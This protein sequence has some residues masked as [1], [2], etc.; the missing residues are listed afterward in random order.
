MATSYVI[1]PIHLPDQTMIM[2]NRPA[3]IEKNAALFSKDAAPPVK[4]ETV[5][6]ALDTTELPAEA[7]AA[8]VAADLVVEAAIA[9][10]VAVA[11][12]VADPE[13]I[14]TTFENEVVWMRLLRSTDL[15]L[16][17]STLPSS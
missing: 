10:V 3:H 17:S 12:A 8:L 4:F 9:V 16:G 2:A 6:L 5:G 14:L 13:I 15:S 7:V 1:I 11:G